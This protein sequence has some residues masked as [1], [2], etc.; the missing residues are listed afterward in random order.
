MTTTI[1]P[2]VDVEPTDSAETGIETL[3]YANRFAVWDSE[4]RYDGRIRVP[5]GVKIS[6]VEYAYYGRD[7]KNYITAVVV[8]RGQMGI[9]QEYEIVDLT[10]LEDSDVITFTLRGD[11]NVDAAPEKGQYSRT[12]QL[13]VRLSL[14]D[15]T[16]RTTHVPVEVLWP[17]YNADQGYAG[18]PFVR[19]PYDTGWGG[20]PNSQAGFG[21]VSDNGYVAEKLIVDL[22]NPRQGIK[23]VASN[24]SDHVYWQLLHEDGTPSHLTPDPVKLNVKGHQG[25]GTGDKKIL[26]ALNLR[27]AGDKPGYYRFLVWP[28]S[29]DTASGKTSILSWDRNKLEDAFQIGS[30]YYRYTA[31]GATGARFDVVPGGPPDVKLSADGPVGY[32][33]VRLSTDDGPVPVHDVQVALPPGMGLAFVA[34]GNPGYMLTVLDADGAA[35]HYRGQLSADGQ[36]LTFSKV[37]LAL[38]GK[39]S[40]S[41]A[42]VA[43]RATDP[44]ATGRTSL[45]FQVG[46]QSSRSTPIE[47]GA[48]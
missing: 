47:V 19:L 10:F 25:G 32:P 41:I 18:R 31:T 7:D 35:K 12:Y 13:G 46:S 40:N 34:E 5:A 37:N 22:V 44:N 43:V 45:T 9:N 24:Y 42:F 1:E 11:L 2:A 20:T 33:G 23:D 3:G 38:A 4:F 48:G 17:H 26:E 28:Q 16:T 14:N 36:T 21:Y 27:D 8:P 39:S 29:I 6:K 15:G 30:I